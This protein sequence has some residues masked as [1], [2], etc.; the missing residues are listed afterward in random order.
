MS[1]SWNSKRQTGQLS[2]YSDRLWAAWPE[3]DS[4]QG[5]HIFFPPYRPDRLLRPTQSP[6]SKQVT[7]WCKPAVMDIRGFLC[8][9]LGGSI[10]Q[11]HDSLRSRCTCSEAGFS[12]QNGDR[13]WG[14]FYRTAMFCLCAFC[15]Q[16]DSMQRILIK[17]CFP[18]YDGKCLSR[19]TV[20][21]L[22]QTFRW[23]RR[24]WNGGAEVAKTTNSQ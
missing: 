12:S 8:V 7:N 14:V 5:E 1:C 20:Q 15:E 24:C 22:K 10:V 17:K 11:L 6:I 18:V 23:W 21:P 16:K 3:F 9:S 4:R 19:K 2:R 13:A